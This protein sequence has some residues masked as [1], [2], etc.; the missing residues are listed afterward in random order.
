MSNSNEKTLQRRQERRVLKALETIM[1]L[2]NEEQRAAV[3]PLI[4]K[5]AEGPHPSHNVRGSDASSFDYICTHC[6]ACDH[7]PG[8]WGNLALPCPT[9]G[10]EPRNAARP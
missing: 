8:G 9:P 4:I 2:G 5:A 6:G 1:L 7:V 3:K 10:G